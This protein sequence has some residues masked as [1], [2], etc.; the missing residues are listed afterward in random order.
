MND[1][2]KNIP[3]IEDDEIDLI[4]LVKNI[5]ERRKFILK[6]VIIF[7][8][9]GIIVALV[10]PPLYTSSTKMIPQSSGST[11]RMSGGLS[12]LA[13][14][15]G[16]NLNMN[17][18]SIELLPQAYPQIVQSIP[19]QLKLMQSKFT[20]SDVE[21]PVTLFEYYTGHSK[22]GVLSIIKK[23]TIGLPG[24]I[25]KAIKDEKF[26][27]PSVGTKNGNA[28]KLT[29][30]QESVRK[31]ISKNISLEINDKDGFVQLSASF[32]EAELS[33]QVAQ[34]AQELLQQY[35]T[36]FKVEKASEQLDFIEERYK[37]KKKEFQEAQ[38][39]LAAFRDRNKN[40]TSAMAFTE[41]ERLQNE[42]QL[43]FEVYLSLAQ[44]LEQ[45]R[46]KVKE[47][48]PVF[49]VIQPVVVPQEPTKPNRKI[50]LIIWVFL[51][52]LVSIGWIFANQFLE[53]A[54]QHWMEIDTSKKKNSDLPTE[55]L[56]P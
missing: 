49:S 34:K 30:D 18:S 37:E 39:A 31:V 11:Q 6:T 45:A 40:V 28:I 55:N 17:Q 50:I 51:G 13:S 24:V 22:P 43:A 29:K 38:A 26:E 2:N 4:A 42:Y 8:V 12:S 53:S 52:G 10:S 47:D 56:D 9:I 32:H 48:T 21:Q 7:A 44:Q 1:K 54:K 3:V 5:W 35:I 19:F 33:A 23:Y 20:F 15:A 25:N 41:Q 14:M 16:I 36:D 46:I 27:T